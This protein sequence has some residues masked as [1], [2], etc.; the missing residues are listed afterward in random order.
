MSTSWWKFALLLVGIGFFTA[1]VEAAAGQDHV[2]AVPAFDAASI[3]PSK[4]TDG[5]WWM[6]F[7]PTGFS[8]HG[9]KLSLLIEEAYGLDWYSGR[10]LGIPPGWG[11]SPFDIEARMD[12]DDEAAYVALNMDARRLMLQRL[13]RERFNLSSTREKRERAVYLLEVGDR[14]SKIGEMLVETEAEKKRLALITKM[15]PG[16]MEAERISMAGL[17]QVLAESTGRQ[18]LDRTGMPGRYRVTLRWTPDSE[19][20]AEWPELSTAIREQLGLRLVA[21]K[22]PVEVVIVSHFDRPSP[23]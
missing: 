22:V 13:L 14:G 4:I 6:R 10:V 2:A 21:A 17:A 18:V 3:K 12:A 19:D 16:F 11:E 7:T 15:R 1:S 5:S 20:A 9:V 23:D 8:A